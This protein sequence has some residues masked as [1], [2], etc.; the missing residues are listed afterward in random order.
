MPRRLL[1][2]GER[3]DGGRTVVV[4]AEPLVLHLEVPSEEADNVG[5]DRQT[6]NLL[7]GAER[8]PRRKRAGEVGEVGAVAVGCDVGGD[9]YKCK[10][11]SA[12]SDVIC[13]VHY[14]LSGENVEDGRAYHCRKR[15][16]AR[17]ERLAA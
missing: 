16:P 13:W 11:E 5:D 12:L 15:E 4:P 9:V 7:F 10:V 6:G 3:G 17:A 1:Q 8:L 2:L 14:Q